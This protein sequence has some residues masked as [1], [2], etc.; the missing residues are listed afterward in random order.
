MTD[1]KKAF[2]QSDVK[3]SNA[4][5]HARKGY[6]RTLDHLKE[7]IA[8]GQDPGDIRPGANPNASNLLTGSTLAEKLRQICEHGVAY[9]DPVE[10]DQLTWTWSS[11]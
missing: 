1:E 10:V 7:C 11:A 8:R 3:L 6:G 9:P 2:R 5:E 4:L